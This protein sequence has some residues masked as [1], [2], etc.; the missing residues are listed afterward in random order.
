MHPT[1]KISFFK[2][3]F[4]KR[5]ILYYPLMNCHVATYSRF[6]SLLTIYK[7]PCGILK[8]LMNNVLTQSCDVAWQPRLEKSKLGNLT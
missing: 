7:L 8:V 1:S 6:K 4:F 5:L 3:K 2:Y